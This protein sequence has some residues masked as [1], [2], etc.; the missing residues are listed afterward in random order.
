MTLFYNGN[1]EATSQ[2]GAEKDP[3]QAGPSSHE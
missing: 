1:A 3:L 2:P